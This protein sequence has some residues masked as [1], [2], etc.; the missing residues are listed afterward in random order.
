MNETTKLTSG[1]IEAA[2]RAAYRKSRSTGAH[3]PV[4]TL[5]LSVK[6]QNIHFSA[7]GKREALEFCFIVDGQLGTTINVGKGYIKP[8]C[9]LLSEGITGDALLPAL[10]HVQK[11]PAAVLDE[12]SGEGEEDEDLH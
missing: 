4:D 2:I 5:G 12:E 6:L 8:L 3:V 9:R 11:A 10:L 1:D 7:W